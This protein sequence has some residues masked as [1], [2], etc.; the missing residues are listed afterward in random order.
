MKG[1]GIVNSKIT[2]FCKGFRKNSFEEVI[3]ELR[4]VRHYNRGNEST[5]LGG[6]TTKAQRAKPSISCLNKGKIS[7]T[8][9]LWEMSGTE[10]Y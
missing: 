2:S 4:S 7:G 6:R 10:T 1:L 3:F 9:A 8:G 5:C